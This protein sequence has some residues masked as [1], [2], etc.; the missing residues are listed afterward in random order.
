MLVT[1][2][3]DVPGSAITTVL[4]EVSGLTVRSRNIGVQFGAGLK[5]LGGG[6][7]KG[8]TTQLEQ[9]RAEAVARLVATAEAVDATAVVAMRYDSNELDQNFQ[10]VVAYGTAVVL[11]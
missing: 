4:G 5:A 2:M 1:T 8:L 11:G 9:T 7:L 6:E 3:N 10:E